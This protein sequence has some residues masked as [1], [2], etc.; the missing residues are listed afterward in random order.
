MAADHE[1][2][3]RLCLEEAA[4]GGAEGNIAVG[5]VVVRD[6]AA[7]AAGRNLVM[8]TLDPTAHAEVVALREAGRITRSVDFSGWSLYTS[9]E[10]CPMCCGA[11]IASGI[12]TLV[13]GA[14]H[15]PAT[16]RWGPYT[17]ERLLDL[18]GWAGRLQLVT[19]VM[20][21]EC[22]AVRQEWDARNAQRRSGT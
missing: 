8:S 20:T 10:P 11:I 13:L 1:R 17:A 18:A 7:V 19:G 16:S 21:A 22:L 3:M 15:D 2:F 4:R 6:G 14:R 9:F 12:A 5:S